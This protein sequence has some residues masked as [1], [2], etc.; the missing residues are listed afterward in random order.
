MSSG[1]ENTFIKSTHFHLPEGVYKMKN[2]NQYVGGIADVWYSGLA[3]DLWVEYK[4]LV[5]PSRQETMI[6]LTG[7]QRPP[8]APLQQAWLRGRHAEGRNVAV[9][10]GS[11]DGGVFFPGISWEK[12]FSTGEYL[13]RLKSRKDLALLIAGALA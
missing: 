2:H 11:K 6:H 4:F 9:I 1:P 12:S 10:L 5:V 3:G 7:G 13:G 8:L